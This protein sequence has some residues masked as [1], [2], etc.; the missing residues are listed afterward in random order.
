MAKYVYMVRLTPIYRDGSSIIGN[1]QVTAYESEK[2]AD[3][4]IKVMKARGLYLV[5]KE[6]VNFVESVEPKQAEGS[7]VSRFSESSSGT[8]LTKRYDTVPIQPKPKE[9]N[10]CFMWR[11]FK[12]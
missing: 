9:E 2:E 10:A 1:C 8:T 6:K 11:L 7:H 5:Q 12:L 3:Q 4:Y